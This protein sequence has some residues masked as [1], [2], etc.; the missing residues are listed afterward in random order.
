MENSINFTNHNISLGDK[1]NINFLLNQLNNELH[2]AF[3]S[4]SVY[5]IKGIKLASLN[6]SN[7]WFDLGHNISN[8]D[9]IEN[10]IHG[11]A[12]QDKHVWHSPISKDYFVLISAPL[13]SSLV[14]NN[15]SNII[16][17]KIVGVVVASYPVSTLLEGKIIQNVNRDTILYLLSNNGTVVYT[18]FNNLSKTNP[19]LSTSSN[20]IIGSKFNDQP[21]YSQ[22]K[23]SSKLVESGIYHHNNSDSRNVLFVAAKEPTDN[24]AIN[25]N[26]VDRNEDNLLNNLILV[27]ELDAGIAFKDMFNL[28]NAFV[29]STIVIL[30]GVSIVALL[31]S[32][33][34]SRPLIRLKDSALSI[35]NGN[36]NHIIK[37]V[38]ADE[39]R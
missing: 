30:I 9:I 11:K 16:S 27:S 15:Y 25:Y 4:L 2:K 20:S 22:I 3:S 24:A 17:N 13:Y 28:R 5:N 34:I 32:R 29:I 37:P 6:N 18:T 35:A 23:D 33:S 26:Q 7:N 8:R 21:I 10:S 39:D 31:A 36:L 38:S 14:T 12:F 19:L 1:N